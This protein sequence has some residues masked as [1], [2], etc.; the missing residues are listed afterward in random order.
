MYP[1]SF[2]CLVKSRLIGKSTN[3]TLTN[4]VVTNGQRFYK[5]VRT[6]LVRK[7]QD[8]EVKI[9]IVLFTQRQDTQ[10]ILDN[11]NGP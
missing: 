7:Q 5:N 10:V 11:I 2:S 9:Y 3:V 6:I 1:L 4:K 8:L